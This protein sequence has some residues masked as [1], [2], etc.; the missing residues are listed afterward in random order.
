MAQRVR[1]PSG[2]KTIATSNTPEPLAESQDSFSVL[3]TASEGNS[4]VVHIGGP[5]VSSSSYPLI[6]GDS[7][8]ID[9]IDPANVYVY[10][11]SGDIVY[12]IGATP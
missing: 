2:T 9:R 8:G 4:E 1:L 12:W 5:E 3:I 7:L 6:K 11:K 10:G